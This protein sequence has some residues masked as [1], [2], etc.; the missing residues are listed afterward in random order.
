MTLLQSFFDNRRSEFDRLIMLTLKLYL[1]PFVA[2]PSRRRRCFDGRYDI[3]PL[4]RF[5]IVFL[6]LLPILQIRD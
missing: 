4:F 2:R 1:S 3:M 5:R 6:L